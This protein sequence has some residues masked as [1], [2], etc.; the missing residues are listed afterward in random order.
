MLLGKYMHS[1]DIRI[2]TWNRIMNVTARPVGPFSLPCRECRSVMNWMKC[3][4]IQ[5]IQATTE[6]LSIVVKC[7]PAQATTPIIYMDEPNKYLCQ[8]ITISQF[9]VKLSSLYCVNSVLCDGTSSLVSVSV[10]ISSLI[11]GG[12][13]APVPCQALRCWH[14]RELLVWGGNSGVWCSGAIGELILEKAISQ[15]FKFVN[16]KHPCLTLLLRCELLPHLHLW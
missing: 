7:C 5:R 2:M 8:A 15:Q 11:L 9:A 14:Q 12:G 3:S 6:K 13:L 1:S 10:S 16:T 4:A